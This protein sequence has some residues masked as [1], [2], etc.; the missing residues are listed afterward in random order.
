MD[1][2]LV[3]TQVYSTIGLAHTLTVIIETRFNQNTGFDRLKIVELFGPVFSK[4]QETR[5][6]ETFHAITD[7]TL[8]HVLG[9]NSK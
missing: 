8:S 9:C 4:L 6:K 7:N 2:R 1:I 3:L 5:W